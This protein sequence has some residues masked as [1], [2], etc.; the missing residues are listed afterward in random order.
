MTVRVLIAD[1]NDAVRSEISEIIRREGWIVCGSFS[2]GQ[3][4]VARAAELKP[5]V[6]ILDLQMPQRDGLSAGCAIRAFLPNVPL[7]V[8]TLFASPY[9]ET[10][11]K[12]LGFRGVIQK[13]NTA[14][15]TSAIRSA[16][17]GAVASD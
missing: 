14:A 6:V 17:S 16:L 8:Y 4:A 10:E 11:A 3:S 13:G 15:L 5:D 2:D 7:L 12:R 9:L 1:D